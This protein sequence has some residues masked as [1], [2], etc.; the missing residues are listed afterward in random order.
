MPQ[1]LSLSPDHE[2][3]GDFRRE[4]LWLVPPDLFSTRDLVEYVACLVYV[5]YLVYVAGGKIILEQETP[6]EQDLFHSR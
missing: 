6:A 1:R 3:L 5:T 2:D 4:V